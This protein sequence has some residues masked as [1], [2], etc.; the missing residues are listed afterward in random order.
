MWAR[1]G[2]SRLQWLLNSYTFDINV[3]RNFLHGMACCN[4]VCEE[5][6]QSFIVKKGL[7]KTFLRENKSMGVNGPANLQLYMAKELGTKVELA[8]RNENFKFPPEKEIHFEGRHGNTLTLLYFTSIFSCT[9]HK[10]MDS[11]EK[12]GLWNDEDRRS[13]KSVEY[14]QVL[15]EKTTITLKRTGL[16]AYPMHAGQ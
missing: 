3:L 4:Y 11:R 12:Q 10:V 6:A 15:T 7:R 5:V 14:V 1:G 2:T 8:K 9:R 16:M 13:G